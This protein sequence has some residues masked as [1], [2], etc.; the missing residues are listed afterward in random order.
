M[1]I[2]SDLRLAASAR[3]FVGENL[4]VGSV[5]FRR[6][7]LFLT[8]I[9]GPILVGFFT[10]D[11][12]PAL[13]AAVAGMLLSFADNDGA[14]QR[15]WR[16]LAIDAAAMG[17]AGLAGHLSGQTAAAY[18]PLLIAIALAAGFAARGGR[19]ALLVGRH[20][21]I[22]FVVAAGVPA[23]PLA[24][25]LYLIGVVLL[26]A[27]ARGIDYWLWRA[28]PLLPV[29]PAQKP[30]SAGGWLRY[31]LAFAAAATVGMALGDMIG[32]QHGY[33]IVIT[34]L[35]VMQPDVRGSFWRILERVA[36]TLAGVAAAW[37]IAAAIHSETINC[38]AILI[39]APLIPHH[40]TKRYWL[41]TGLIALMVLLAYDLTQF[42]SQGL[43]RLPLER[44]E[45]ILLGC[46]VAFA[47]TAAAFPRALISQLY[48]VAAA[49]MK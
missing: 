36:G 27:L 30:A 17:V 11:L 14:L 40:L 23:F 24:A 26:A 12:R 48:G 43:G 46:A 29:A 25:L 10:G 22:A 39:V 44:I 13:T 2:M 38:V 20:S 9:G 47:G 4:A 8:A 49:K 37:A 6:G 33:W 32:E 16:L 45:D 18:W 34:T 3:D 1:V 31:T 19:E 7:A 28:L 41:H 21:A 15:R 5:P 42:N 35:V